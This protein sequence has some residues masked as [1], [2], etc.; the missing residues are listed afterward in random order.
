M[1]KIKYTVCSMV[2]L[3]LLACTD[4]L[5]RTPLDFISPENYLTNE[6]QAEILLNGVYNS[7]AFTSGNENQ[8]FWPVHMASFTDDVYDMQPWH[9]TTM[10]A[11]GQGSAESSWPKWKWSQDYQGIAR[12]NVFLDKIGSSGLKSEKVPRFIAEAKFLRAWYYLDLVTYY[13]DVPLVL[14]PG[15]LSNGFPERD[16]KAVV[17]EQILK[18]LNEAIPDLPLAYED[19]DA[20]RVTRGAA[21]GVKARTLLYESRWAEAAQ[22]AKDVMDLHV[23]TLYPDY[24]GLFLEKNEVAATCEVMF[25]KYYT[26]GVD[27]SWIYM[28]LGE[29][30]AFS[31]TKQL[32]DAYYMNDGWPITKSKLFDPKNPHLNRDSRFYASIYY[33]GC[34]YLNYKQGNP[35]PK[36]TKDSIR[37]PAWVLNTSGFRAKKHWDGTLMEAS[38]EG[39][40]IYFMRY[41]E[42]LLTY[43]EAQN[44]ANG[45][46]QSVYAAIDELR[47]RCKMITLTQAMPGLSKEEM[48]EVIRNERRIELV[49]EGLRWADIRRW[50]IGEKVM[51]DAIGYDNSLLKNY[52]G[53][54]KGESEEWVYKEIVIDTRQFN[55]KRDY[56]W[57]IPLSEINANPNMVQNPGY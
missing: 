42:M 40:N 6:N 18:D 52:P 12:A 39:R 3:C 16:P 37:I 36:I 56:L 31:P 47:N 4:F 41:A 21:M 22:T 32:I 14:I 24:Q 10:W 11:R 35:D 9:E 44:E 7:L 34:K 25:Q 17:V 13:G 19:S 2:L 51:V 15:D 46:E 28:L 20:G 53:D 1:K 38:D 43:A 48:R 26:G 33:P 50:K 29:Y 57:P 30:P 5:E 8:R 23:Y 27:P 55:P 49:F 54:G 45:P